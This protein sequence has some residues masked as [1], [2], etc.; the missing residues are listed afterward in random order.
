MI[1]TEGTTIHLTR[2]DATHENYNRLAFNFPIYN[3]GTKQEE[4][5]LFQLDDKI[6]FI[7]INKKGYTKEEILRKEYTL[8]ELGYT[9]PAETVDI[10]LTEED[11]KNF[12]LANKPM[13]YWYQISLND[14]T[15]VLGHDDDGAKRIIVYPEVEEE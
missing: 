8:R 15:T 13:T 9:A 10:V 6:S 4:N 5:Y 7:V 2:G 11:T 1:K 3:F 12:P 14:T